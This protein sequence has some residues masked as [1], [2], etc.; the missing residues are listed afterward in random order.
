M[1]IA[2][3]GGCFRYP[4]KERQV[5]QDICFSLETGDVLAILGPNGAGKTTMLRCLMGLLKWQAG[6]TMLN[7]T[8]LRSIPR[9]QFWNLVSYVP[10]A[11]QVL[12]A[13]TVEEMVLL[14]RTAEIRPFSMPK[15]AD[16]D[17]VDAALTKTRLQGIRKRF[18]SELSGGEFQMVLIARALV[19]EPQV[20]ILDEPESN[21]DFQNQ[22]LVLEMISQLASEGIICIFNTHYPAH[23]L[24]RANKALMLAKDG[25]YCF[26][27][28]REIVTESNILRYFGVRSVIG[29]LET[30]DT[31]YS[32]V[33]PIAIA[34][35]TENSGSV[36]AEQGRVIAGMTVLLEENAC[37]EQLN[38]LLH[39]YESEMIGRMGLPYRAGG[40]YI[41]TLTMD[42]EASRVLALADQI[43]GLHGAHVK[44][45]Y[46]AKG[47]ANE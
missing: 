34:E 31:A 24:R 43:A 20:L 3:Q 37:A 21:L 11:K 39:E 32:D 12:T 29:A 36:T 10:Q 38:T 40:V 14:G 28:V 2:V 1:Q 47:K 42:T 22:L 17:A 4:R 45:N 46:I 9:K 23:A 8:P 44:T 7:G 16:L 33:V 41:L 26:G 6:E 25:T 35:H 30:A 18:C 5:L 27:A 15:Q 19:S 13:Y